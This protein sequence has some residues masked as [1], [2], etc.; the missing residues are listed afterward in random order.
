MPHEKW[1]TRDYFFVASDRRISIG[2]EFPSIT[3]Q[4]HFW[5]MITEV[6]SWKPANES[7]AHF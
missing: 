1:L 7:K 5:Q 6:K 3:F 2:L 4:S